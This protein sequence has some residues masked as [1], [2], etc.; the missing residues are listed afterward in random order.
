MAKSKYKKSYRK[1]GKKTSVAKLSKRVDKIERGGEKELKTYDTDASGTAG[2]NWQLLNLSS[3]A[4][5]STSLT[6]EGLQIRPKHLTLKWQIESNVNNDDVTRV[7]IILFR[8]KEMHGTNPTIA[9]LLEGVSPD[10][11]SFPEHDTRPRFTII[12]DKV[13]TL[14]TAITGTET[15]RTGKFYYVFPKNARI[16]YQGTTAVATDMGKNQMYVFIYATDNT[17]QIG[18]NFNS[19]LR[20]TE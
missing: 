6:R 8:D 7:R 12:R 4:Q 16:Y 11:L 14:N 5:G 2:T 13:I 1:K 17:Y 3:M 9:Q 18:Y 15:G 10:E 19:R 20:F